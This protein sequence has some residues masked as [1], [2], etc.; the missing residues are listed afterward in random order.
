MPLLFITCISNVTDFFMLLSNELS[1]VCNT[2]FSSAR[3]DGIIRV[4]TEAEDR[5]ASAEDLQAFED[6]LSK[7]TIDPKTGDLGDIKMEDLPGREHLNEPGNKTE[8]YAQCFTICQMNVPGDLIVEANNEKC[9][10]IS[11]SR[12]VC[13]LVSLRES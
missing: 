2:C 5:M 1:I 9:H 6:E 7:A 13:L 3:S 12:W 10:A 8:K 11:A 4:F